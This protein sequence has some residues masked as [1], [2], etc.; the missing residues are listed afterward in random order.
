MAERT[1]SGGTTSRGA[2]KAK[3]TAARTTSTRGAAKARA[4]R[5]AGEATSRATRRR[6]ATTAATSKVLDQANDVTHPERSVVEEPPPAPDY[7][8]FR[9]EP[10]T[11]M[12][13][14]DI[15]PDESEGYGRK[16]DVNDELKRHRDR[17]TDLQGRLYGEQRRSLL[18]VLQAMDTGGKDGTIKGVFQGV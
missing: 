4:G 12:R 18:I 8:R 17:I 7:P 6:P 1:R 10:G 11:R 15:D 9:V 5:S 16:K 3:S 14:A 2:A 13:L